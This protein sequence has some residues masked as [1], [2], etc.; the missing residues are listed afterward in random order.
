MK[1]FAMHINNQKLSFDIFMVRNVQNIFMKHDI[2]MIFGITEKCIILTH[3]MYCC[4][5]LQIYPCCLW[6]CSRETYCVSFY[7]HLT[8]SLEKV[9]E[10]TV[11]E[12]RGVCRSLGSTGRWTVRR[13]SR[14]II[15]RS[16]LRTATL[17]W[18]SADSACRW[19]FTPAS[20]AALTRTSTACVRTSRSRSNTGQTSRR[21]LISWKGSWHEKSN[22]LWF[23]LAYKRY[24][25]H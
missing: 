25:Y 5:L 8:I 1:F 19:S 6:L 17:T 14:S 2:L 4:L 9:C 21:Q 15:S 12:S 22:L 13:V 23:F 18:C 3:T 10:C 7:F 24:L 16:G 20:G 11:F